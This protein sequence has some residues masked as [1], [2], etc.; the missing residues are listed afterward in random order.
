MKFV[1]FLL[2][3]EIEHPSLGIPYLGILDG[4]IIEDFGIEAGEILIKIL[5][6]GRTDVDGLRWY[7]E[8]YAEKR[9]LS[10]VRLRAP[11]PNPPG[12]RD[13]YAFEQ[14]V[15]SAY[16]VAGKPVPP[17]WY[18]FPAFYFGNHAATYGPNDFIP[19][20]HGS[21]ALDY[22]L[23][24]ACVI[25]KEGRNIPVSRAEDYIMGF[26]IY[27]DWSARDI[28]L[29]EMAIGLGPTKGKDFANSFGPY[30]ITPDE[31]EAHKTDRPGVYDLAMVARVNG[32]ERSRG[33]WKD[34]HYSFG[35]MIAYAS[36]DATLKPG[37]IIGS[38]TVGTGCLLELTK[39]QGP[40]LKPGDV[41]EL[42]IEG[43]GILQNTVGNQ[44]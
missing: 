8:Q 24:V 33:N 41:V 29:R 20:P 23:E 11:L 27:N 9:Q 22:E 12:L 32:E 25:A 36:R 4:E 15:K 43:L 37:D 34:M 10:S 2:P 19:Y 44:V 21:N 5:G 26:M 30:L 35:E 13:F 28:Q 6:A 14:H 1:S 17:V 16:E 7:M 38:G 40:W 3:I 39:G 31:L 18:E 42:E